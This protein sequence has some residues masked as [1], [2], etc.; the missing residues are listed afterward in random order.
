[1]V[2]LPEDPV[3]TV[4]LPEDP[5]AMVVPLQVV[6]VTAVNKVVDMVKLPLQHNDKK[7][8]TKFCTFL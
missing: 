1:M 2:G 3:A 5:V 7:R 8:H 6:Q 4:E